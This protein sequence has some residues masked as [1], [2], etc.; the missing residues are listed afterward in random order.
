[1]FNLFFDVFRVKVENW[2][3]VCPLLLD[4]LFGVFDK[5]PEVFIRL[6]TNF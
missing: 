6:Q 4:F 2:F 1:M 3:F 5:L